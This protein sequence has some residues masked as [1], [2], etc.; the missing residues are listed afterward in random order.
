M[1][2]LLNMRFVAASIAAVAAIAVIAISNNEDR[3][4]TAAPAQPQATP[5]FSKLAAAGR[6]ALTPEVRDA[7]AR[8]G[9]TKDA[10]ISVAARGPFTVVVAR[11]K[12]T[13]LALVHNG[14]QRSSIVYAPADTLQTKPAW[15]A[16]TDATDAGGTTMAMLVPDGSDSV[17]V[18]ETGGE[19]STVAV[20]GNI[21]LV[22][23]KTLA[24]V[25]YRFG[26]KPYVAELA[27][28]PAAP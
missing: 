24:S 6:E 15:V 4:A 19:K 14:T 28:K 18:T 7:L 12:L 23:S 20:T 17:E 2:A 27:P 25:T 21:A 11:D 8:A 10:A 5:A 9:V 1:S 26:G 16:A 13:Y 3:A 22:Q